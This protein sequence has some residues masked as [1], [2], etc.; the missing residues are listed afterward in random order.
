MYTKFAHER[1]RNLHEAWMKLSIIYSRISYNITGDYELE[2]ITLS[3]QRVK[4]NGI[5]SKESNIYI[6]IG[7]LPMHRP[8]PESN[9]SLP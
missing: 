9:V 2:Q 7:L 1:K 4:V 3:G 5:K 8:A 6:Y